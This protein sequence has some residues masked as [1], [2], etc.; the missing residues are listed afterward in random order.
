M[1]PATLR[2]VGFFLIATSVAAISLAAT[3]GD[4]TN[5]KWV[6]L[7]STP[8]TIVV[9]LLNRA[10][11]R[12]KLNN[13]IRGLIGSGVGIS[14]ALLLASLFP[15]FSFGL[16]LPVGVVWLASSC[17]TFALAAKLSSSREW[18]RVSAAGILVS[19]VLAIAVLGGV[20]LV[21]AKALPAEELHI[22]IV[23][24]SPAETGVLEWASVDT[25]RVTG[26]PLL[27]SLQ[28]QLSPNLKGTLRL[29]GEWKVGEGTATTAILVLS[30]PL[31]T[32]VS[33]PLP[34]GTTMTFYQV[35]NEWVG[36]PAQDKG[37]RRLEI[38][39]DPKQNGASFEVTTTDKKTLRGTIY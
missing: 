4:Y 37:G 28:R 39:H 34:P 9:A 32:S 26:D 36:V 29:N 30:N 10:L 7:W 21:R 24:H 22:L 38:V 14:Y 6:L 12:G 17:T 15:A 23:Q 16:N 5:V 20:R 2:I 13:F 11:L 3:R 31:Q 18:L 35:D 8:L 25:K 19:A 27:R 1:L 33:L